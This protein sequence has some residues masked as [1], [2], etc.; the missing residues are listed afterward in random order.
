MSN[1]ITFIVGNGLDIRVGLR[2]SYRDFYNYI[3]TKK[4]NSKNRIYNEIK[5][6]PET[7]ADFEFS[8]GEYTRYLDKLP[9][10]MRK[11]QA[12][13]LHEELAEITVD[14]AQY[15]RALDE[16]SN[17]KIERI[18]FDDED[19]YREL[20]ADNKN[21]LAALM[22][23]SNK[24]IYE[25]I[26]LNYTTTLEKILKR[27]DI[28]LKVN[29]NDVHHI[30]GDL[31][32]YLVLGVSNETQISSSLHDD[33]MADLIKPEILK[34]M[35]DGRLNTMDQILRRSNIVVIFGASL[36]DTDQ[37]MW[38]RI[39]SWLSL[40]PVRC[41]V[42]HTYDKNYTEEKSTVPRNRKR[43]MNQVKNRLFAG[44]GLEPSIIEELK[45]RIFVVYNTKYLFFIE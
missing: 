43:F 6:S 16:K 5:S 9:L 23:A 34:S 26:T 14:L 10:S 19:F 25:F 28:K 15:L 11:D 8:F 38:E 2:T 40:H 29:S 7:W 1:H 21:R 33:E 20:P 42:I 13:L 18:N 22:S 39:V 36:G 35:G 3:N 32:D 31:S 41:V 12:M 24:N 4:P 30:H 37:Y 27:P 44:S 45:S 17:D